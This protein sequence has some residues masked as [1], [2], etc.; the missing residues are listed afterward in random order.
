MYETDHHYYLNYDHDDD[1]QDPDGQLLIW[2][3]LGAARPPGPPSLSL[4]WLL[5]IALLSF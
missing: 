5:L 1:E 2:L 3:E 4:V